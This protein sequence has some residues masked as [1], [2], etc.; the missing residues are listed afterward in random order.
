MVSKITIF[1]AHFDG[2][3]FGPASLE[4]PTGHGEDSFDHEFHETES[5]EE[6]ASKS[7]FTTFLQGAAVFVL[8]FVT[9]WVVL[10]RVL[11]GEEEEADP[12]IE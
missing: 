9:L 3:Q 10:S 8:M 5:A 7:S 6:H 2:A 4:T 1:E 11:E 12:D